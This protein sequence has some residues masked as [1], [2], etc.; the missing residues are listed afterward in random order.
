MDQVQE[1]S[2]KIVQ[3]INGTPERT[4]LG[5]RLGAALKA[6]FPEFQPYEYRCRNLRQFIGKYI[7]AVSEKGRSGADLVYTVSSG[8]GEAPLT[9]SRES[10]ASTE[11]EYVRLPTNSYNW[12]AYSNP[13]YPYVVVANRET[14]VLQT[15]PEG[16]SAVSPWVIVP[17]PTAAVHSNIASE[18]VSGLPEPMRTNLGQLLRDQKWYVR[19][20]SVALRNGLGPRW[21]S[22]RR[23]KLSER[24]NSSLRDLAIPEFPGSRPSQSETTHLVVPTLAAAAD[25]ESNFRD[26]ISKVVSELPLSELR[27]LKLPVGAVFDALKRS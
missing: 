12:K 19:F 21:A 26:I 6:N 17:K 4:I 10:P 11:S 23:A 27:A 3:L 18:F 22:F 2:E 24:F 13:A 7:P 1:I 9:Q 16:S 25:E 20:S 5:V 14:G 8:T 15:I